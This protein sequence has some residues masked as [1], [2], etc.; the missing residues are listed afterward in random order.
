MQVLCHVSCEAD[1][2][3]LGCFGHLVSGGIHDHGWVVIIFFHHIFQILLPPVVE[4]VDIVVFCLVDIPDIDKFIH[5]Q[6][7]QTVAGL[8]QCLGTRIVGGADS[9]VAVFFENTDLS[10]FGV[11]IAAGT[12]D[13]VVMMDAGSA[14]DYVLAVD[15]DPIFG[16]PLQSA[17]TK[18]KIFDICDR[19]VCLCSIDGSGIS[20]KADGHVI[21]IRCIRCPECSIRDG[22]LGGQL[23]RCVDR[24]RDTGRFLSGSR[25]NL[26]CQFTGSCSCNLS[27][28][29]GRRCADGAYAHTIWFDMLWGSHIHPYRPVYTCTGIPAT[30]GLVC[31][32]GDDTD[33]IAFSIYQMCGGIHIKVGIAVGT[34]SHFFPVQPDFGI[35][36]DTLKFKTDLLSLGAFGHVKFFFIDIVIA[37]KPSGIDSPGTVSGS[38]FREHG[39]MRKCN[40]C[41]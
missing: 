13:T 31:I 9:I 10:F 24:D 28:D 1:A 38:L 39:I 17:D 32:V 26:Q 23:S 29:H 5:D 27:F 6:H 8:Q 19:C 25:K 18:G 11:R 37:F 14:Q 12:E 4:I 22:D 40:G 35:V 15:G 3:F 16:I 20:G 41:F 30:V 21:E 34:I 33:L 2:F 36:I 7:T